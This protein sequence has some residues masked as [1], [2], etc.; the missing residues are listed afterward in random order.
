MAFKQKNYA[1]D[2]DGKNETQVLNA[3]IYIQP[4]CTIILYNVIFYLENNARKWWLVPKPQNHSRTLPKF[5]ISHLRV[6]INKDRL[7]TSAK[8]SLI[9]VF[10]DIY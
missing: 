8:N 7:Y 3:Y 4:L 9:V 2:F 5:E 10:C 1:I 6:K